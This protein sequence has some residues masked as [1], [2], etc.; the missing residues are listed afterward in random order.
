MS[1]S[2]PPSVYLSR[3]LSK[4]LIS[5]HSLTHLLTLDPPRPP[6]PPPPP[7]HMSPLPPLPTP[8]GEGELKMLL[9]GKGMSL[10]SQFRLTYSMILNLLRVEDLKVRG[11]EGGLDVCVWAGGGVS[12]WVCGCKRVGSHG[13]VCIRPV[14]LLPLL[15]VPCSTCSSTQ[16]TNQRCKLPLRQYTCSTQHPLPPPPLPPN[17]HTLTLA[18]PPAAA[19][20]GHAAAFIC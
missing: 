8:P 13:L 5:S 4:S 19:G 1:V 15:L 10:S 3:L 7:A 16:C 17:T 14:M 9:Q 11:G 2:Q 6:P 20:G 18:T 12:C